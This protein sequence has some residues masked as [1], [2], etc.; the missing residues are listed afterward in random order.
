MEKSASS[1]AKPRILFILHLPPP[2]HGAAVMGKIVRDS[3]LLAD[4]FEAHW[5][6]LSA[7]ASLAEIGR[8]SL[9]KLGF[10]VRLLRRIRQ[11]MRSFRPDAVYLTPTT[12]SLPALVKDALTARLVRGTGVRLLLH[13]HNK[14]VGVHQDRRLYHLLYRSLFKD[15]RV[16]LQSEL[17]YQDVSQYV[18]SGDA[19]FCPN[20][21]DVETCPESQRKDR[22]ELLFI[23]NLL[24]DK[25]ILELLDACRELKESG[26]PFTC[27]F[28]GAP[29][30]AI[31][32][33]QWRQ[34][35][36]ERGLGGIVRYDGPLYGPH[37]QAVLSGAD[38]FVHPT[39]NDCFPL[40]ILEAMAAGL[41]VVS[42]REGGIP[43]EVED[44]V[45]GILCEKACAQ[46][47]VDAI[48]RLLEDPALRRRMG[49]AGRNRYERLFT[50]DAF[51][52][53]LVGILK[54]NV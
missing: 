43:D 3:R 35:A 40:A 12:T 33:E 29:T 15:A 5:I 24:P 7:S 1:S 32:A 16:L 48:Q 13:L 23:S 50:R 53:R 17:L 10:L 9:R 2:V 21:I 44:G 47:L 45:T 51:E 19:Y 52:K 54:E 36:D 46:P 11:E 41:P 4:S 14:G 25:G 27:R 26:L 8:I 30:P 37:K 34:L 49:E 31:G 20:G 39:R 18:K 6:N 42:T 22:P 28:V 38:V